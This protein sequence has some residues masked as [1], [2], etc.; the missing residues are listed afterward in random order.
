MADRYWIASTSQVWNNTANWSTSSGGSGGASVPG[1]SDVAIFDSGGSGNCTLVGSYSVGSLTINGYSGT[2]YLASAEAGAFG[3][4]LTVS[5]AVSITGSP[6]VTGGSTTDG[7]IELGTGGSFD[8]ATASFVDV[9]LTSQRNVSIK[10]NV[11]LAVLRT[12]AG[13]TNYATTISGNVAFVGNAVVG[14]ATGPS[15]L[16][17]SGNYD[18]EIQDDFTYQGGG[19][20]T[21]G[22]G[23]LTLSGTNQTV[24]FDGE[25]TEG[26][27]INSDGTITLSGNWDIDGSLTINDG[28]LDIDSY[29]LTCDSLTATTGSADIDIVDTTTGGSIGITGALVLNGD[30][31]LDIV[32][33]VNG[34][35]DGATSEAHYTDVQNSTMTVG[36]TDIDASDNCT[37][38]GTN[39]GWDFGG[40]GGTVVPIFVHHYQQQGSL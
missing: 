14:T 4:Q 29:D 35:C 24:D 6:A 25:T 38:T 17:N 10:G 33:A 32:W 40:G 13:T 20:W 9:T 21:A 7:T 27:V 5:V 23:T 34:S 12:V 1:T 39:S 18:I 28:N 8:G 26:T 3:R 37:D 11:P 15:N 19:T 31:T 2:M 22:S 30:A 36:G 16:D